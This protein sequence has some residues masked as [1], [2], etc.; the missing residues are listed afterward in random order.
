MGLLELLSRY[1]RFIV[2]AVSLGILLSGCWDTNTYT[3]RREPVS[4]IKEIQSYQSVV[5]FTST[6]TADVDWTKSDK[7]A[8]RQTRSRPPYEEEGVNI[9]NYEHLGFKGELYVHFFNDRL[10]ST[11]FYPEKHKEYLKALDNMLSIELSKGESIEIRP[12][13]L[14]YFESDAK[15]RNY[16]SW[17]DTRLAKEMSDWIWNYA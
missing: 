2:V 13:V 8:Y 6:L 5:A 17:V 9:L 12:N 15:G 11:L 10:S 7:S 14:L 4:L 16:I 1:A 3:K